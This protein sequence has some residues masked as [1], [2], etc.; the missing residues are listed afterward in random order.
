MT[1]YP[2]LILSNTVRTQEPTAFTGSGNTLTGRPSVS[3]P[4]PSSSKS[5]GKE[6]AKTPE[7]TT[8]S[9][10]NG[11]NTLGSRSSSTRVPPSFRG[12]TGPIE[13]GAGG[14]RVPR[15]P[16]RGK[17]QKKKERSPTPDWDVDDDDVIMI[18]SD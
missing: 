2:I 3:Q 17:A 16:Q 12:P 7:T 10:G 9:W 15:P 11:G 14:A 1:T 8:S 13:L 4:Q 5:K 6:K 18:D